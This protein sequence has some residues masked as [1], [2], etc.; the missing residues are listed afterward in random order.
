[1]AADRDVGRN[2]PAPFAFV[3]DPQHQHGQAVEGETPDHSEG[4]R[5]AQQIDVAVAHQNG[6]ELQEDDQVHDPV[7]GAE[8]GMRL[9][10]PV[11][12][13]AVFGD[14]VEDAVGADDRGID[15]AGE[16][17]EA[18]DHDEGAEDQFQQHRAVLIHGQPGDQVVLVDR[19][20]NRVRD[21]HHEQ[22]GGEPGEDEA[23]NRDDDGGA[24][25]VLEFGMGKL[26]IDLGQ[27]FLAAHGQ[28]GV[29]E[30]DQ[31]AEDA[32]LS[33]QILGQIGVL[34]EAQRFRAELQVVGGGQGDRSGSPVSAG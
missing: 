14:A 26:A 9:A 20:A 2:L 32:E 12:E 15:R 18:H 3:F 19:D 21:D 34:H 16:N 1:M 23:V 6:E 11:G 13:D 10:E 7:G 30:G 28:H 8:A 4:V 25:Q 33:G 22:Q 27:R 5:F 31:N 17:E 24:L 29:A